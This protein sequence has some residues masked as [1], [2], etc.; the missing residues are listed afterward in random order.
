MIE[1]EV[2]VDSRGGLEAIVPV[3]VRGFV[4]Q[5]LVIE[6]VVDTGYTGE[7]S[8]RASD[9]TALGLLQSGEAETT[10][11]DGT[12][13]IEATFT[14]I[15]EWDGIERLSTVTGDDSSALVGIKLL[16]GFHISLDAVPGGNVRITR[17]P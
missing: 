14:A 13:K 9:V 15:V 1:G 4:G 17:L 6:A 2:R 3:I 7:L 16:E 8:L 11:A 5:E 10:L 12:L